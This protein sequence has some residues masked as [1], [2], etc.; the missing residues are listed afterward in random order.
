MNKRFK[1]YDFRFMILFL[2]FFSLI[3]NPKSLFLR[4]A[5]AQQP[6]SP[7]S[8]LVDKIN[9]LKQEIA[10][11]AANLKNEVSKKLQNKAYP[12]FISDISDTQIKLGDGKKVLI[13]EYTQFWNKL[14]NKKRGALDVKELK[15]NDYIVALG[16]VDEKNELK[17][18]L[19]VKTQALASDSSKL[20]WGVIQSVNGG[21]ITLKTKEEKEQIIQTSP[22]TNFVLGNN[23]ASILDAKKGRILV[24]K[25]KMS[26]DRLSARFVYFIPSV[27]FVKPEK[28]AATSSATPPAVPKK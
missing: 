7:S 15:V 23:E 9:A 28:K 18:K 11:K 21:Q 5:Y 25:G 17:A 22:S 26:T 2:V 8:T 1:I 27:G 6:S 13:N 4:Q 3:F 10:S 16:D 24:A 14:T 19:L 12:G 20:V